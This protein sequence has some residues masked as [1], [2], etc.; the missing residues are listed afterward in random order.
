MK[1]TKRDACIHIHTHL[2]VGAEV[3]GALVGDF[4]G[5]KVG[6]GEGELGGEEESVLARSPSSDRGVESEEGGPD[7]AAPRENPLPEVV[8]AGRPP[9]D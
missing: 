1:C 2:S 7:L 6:A 4:E 9:Q 8:E 5:D 3:V